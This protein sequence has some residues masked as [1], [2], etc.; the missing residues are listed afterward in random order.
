ME[1]QD[2]QDKAYLISFTKC[3][4]VRCQAKPHKPKGP[5]VVTPRKS[6]PGCKPDGG[7]PS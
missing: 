7:T 2:Q 1:P 5:K 4:I 6:P 3:S